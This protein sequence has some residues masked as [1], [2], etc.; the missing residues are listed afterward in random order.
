MLFMK[1]FL[2]LIFL[3]Q[4]CIAF[5]AKS[6]NL[7]PNSGFEL[8]GRMP[9]KK[10]NSISR[11]I[12]WIPP[13]Y[14]SDYYHKDASRAVGTPKN[15]FGKQK[16]HSGKA[17]AGICCRKKFQE[18]IEIKLIDTLK[19]DEEYLVELYISRAER[20]IG[21]VKEFGVYFTDKAIWG[22]LQG[23]LFETPQIVFKN[24]KGYKKKKEWM[25][26]SAVYKAKGNESVF[27]FGHFIYDP[28]V[29]K[30]RLF[31]HYY[32]DDVSITPTGH[33]NDSTI[34]KLE[35]IPEHKPFNPK[36]GEIITLENI[37]FRTN[38][39]ELLPESFSEL[40]KLVQLL[41]D[42]PNTTI[43]ISGHTDNTGN[44]D[45]NISLS[46]SRA[47]AVSDYLK[48]KGIDGTRIHYVGYGSAKPIASNKTESGKQQNRRVEFVL[49]KK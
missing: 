5:D 38:K 25:K 1:E 3:C 40:D 49:H 27:V 28:S 12:D 20:S 21:S 41:N 2:L 8:V 32:I 16:P 35:I 17:Y 13:N 7:I 23:G 34:T 31:S 36:F 15:R 37:F 44:E 48:L 45:Q 43:T 26:F 19:K 6:Q 11:S 29:K 9:N 22:L 4:L 42:S 18:Y 46:Q 33:K 30:H 47:K 24:P 10:G 14:Y 39:N